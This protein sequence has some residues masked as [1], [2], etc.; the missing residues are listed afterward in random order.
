MKLIPSAAAFFCIVLFFFVCKI[1]LAQSDSAFYSATSIKL[2]V[3]DLIT[4]EVA[5]SVEEMIVPSLSIE[6]TPSY[7]FSDYLDIY[8]K[9]QNRGIYLAYTP[10]QGR[11]AHGWVFRSGIKCYFDFSHPIKGRKDAYIEPLIILKR[12]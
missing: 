8:L 1:S 10:Y 3:I 4:T 6:V 5:V 11:E 12:E 7:I 9:T 2:K